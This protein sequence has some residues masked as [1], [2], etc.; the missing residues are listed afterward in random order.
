M[1]RSPLNRRTELKPRRSL[2]PYQKAKVVKRQDG[3][4]KCGCGE[5]LGDDPR[6]IDFD[7]IH[8]LWEGGSNDLDNFAALKKKHHLVKTSRKAKERAKCDRLAKAGGRRKP[9]AAER[10]L[11]RLLQKEKA[12]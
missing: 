6:D 10:E 9:T 3:I 12:S 4:C 7:H 5:P 11:G 1:K 8:E 2:S